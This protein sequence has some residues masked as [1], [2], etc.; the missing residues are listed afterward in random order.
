MGLDIVKH[1]SDLYSNSSNRVKMPV[2]HQVGLQKWKLRDSSYLSKNMK[3]AIT[4]M[5]DNVSTQ[6]S[7][8]EQSIPPK[9]SSA[10]TS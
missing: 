4:H 1:L 9:K 7:S 5:L 2:A 6:M 3:V 8:T 10:M